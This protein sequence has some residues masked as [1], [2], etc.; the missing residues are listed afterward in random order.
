[1]VFST[2]FVYIYN[3]IKSCLCTTKDNAPLECRVFVGFAPL[4]V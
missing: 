3:F 1:M 4:V 2:M